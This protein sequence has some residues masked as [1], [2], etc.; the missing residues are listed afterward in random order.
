MARGKS[1]DNLQAK[2]NLYFL[3]NQPCTHIHAILDSNKQLVAEKSTYGIFTIRDVEF[4]TTI[5][6][7]TISVLENEKTRT[8]RQ[9]HSDCFCEF[10]QVSH[11][12]L[13]GNS[14]NGIFVYTTDNRKLSISKSD[15]IAIRDKLDIECI[16]YPK[17]VE[18]FETAV[19]NASKRK[20]YKPIAFI[21]RT[22]NDDTGQAEKLRLLR[23]RYN[24]MGERLNVNELEK[25]IKFLEDFILNR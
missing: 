3:R 10:F 23:Q 20:V 17:S 21:K 15:Y 2:N 6:N 7:T 25:I 19:D 4:Y 11:D 5:S 18:S 22:I 1:Y 8:F 16:E 24:K 14:D 13:L 9:E 12:F